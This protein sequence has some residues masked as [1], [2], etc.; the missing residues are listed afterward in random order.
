MGPKKKKK[1]RANAATQNRSDPSQTSSIPFSTPLCLRL[2]YQMPRAQGRGY[3]CTIQRSPRYVQHFRGYVSLKI[4]LKKNIKS[5][6]L[7]IELR[8]NVARDAEQCNGVS[9]PQVSVSGLGG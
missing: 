4:K 5:V 9:L 1:A 3:F 6:A 8:R 2:G 7:Q